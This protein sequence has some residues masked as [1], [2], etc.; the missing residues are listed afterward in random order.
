VVR[1]GLCAARVGRVGVLAAA[2]ALAGFSAAPSAAS[3]RLGGLGPTRS[4]SKMT[5][6]CQRL[7][8]GGKGA[9]PVQRDTGARFLGLVGCEFDIMAAVDGHGVARCSFGATSTCRVVRPVRSGG[10][11]PSGVT[12]GIVLLRAAPIS[13]T[14][15]VSLAGDAFPEIWELPGL[16]EIDS[17]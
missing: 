14:V 1:R 9:A 13:E 15:F 17:S 7:G 16:A 12:Y 2:D 3:R 8:P 6:R 10:A 5:N 4:N 11:G